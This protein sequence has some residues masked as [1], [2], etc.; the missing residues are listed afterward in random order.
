M[1]DAYE[2]SK[3][4][5]PQSLEADTPYCDKKFTFIQDINNGIYSGAGITLVQFDLSSIYNSSM[6]VDP[7]QMYLTIP[8]TYVACYANATLTG[9]LAQVA[10]NLR[11]SWATCGLKSGFFQIVHGGDL[12]VDGKTIEQFQPYQNAL[13]NF[14]MMSQMSQDD[15]NAYGPSLGMGSVIDNSRSV[16]YNNLNSSVALGVA[17]V[18]GTLQGPIGGNGITNC[19]PFG[20]P[21]GANPDF[22]DQTVYGPQCTSVYNTGLFSRISRIAD[23]T[24]CSQGTPVTVAGAVAGLYASPI[25]PGVLTSNPAIM[26]ATQLQ[27]EFRATYSTDGTY[28][29]WN[30]VAVIRLC[31]VFDSMGK[32]PLTKKFNGLLRLYIN[33][34]ACGAQMLSTGTSS[35]TM[36]TASASTFVNTCPLLMNNLTL[37]NASGAS[38]LVAGL[39]IARPQQTSIYG[40]NLANAT[41]SLGANP[42]TA[43][44]LYFPQVGLKAV[45]MDRYISENRSK[46]V[47]WRAN[48]FNQFSNITTGSSFSGLVQSGVS[49]IEG[50][51]IMPFLSA[52]TNGVLAGGGATQQI[53]GVTPFAQWASPFD[54]APA[55]SA[56][57]SLLNIQIAIGG[58]NILA[59]PYAYTFENFLNQVSLFDKI[60]R[61]DHGI[62]CG[63]ISQA[64]WEQSRVYYFDCSRGQNADLMTPRNVN[65]SFTNNSQQT[66]DCLIYTLYQDSCVIDCETGQISGR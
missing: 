32:F 49:N 59:S 2:F 18:V 22:G 33:T 20:A 39:F 7:A 58:Q 16:R 29:M 21:T 60:N 11:G 38:G 23:V 62:S 5:S 53:T 31:D 37:P 19:A 35:P 14:K 34:G 54:T 48:L 36:F 45:Q 1:S 61:S 9:P 64:F 26:S 10:G 63:L 25:Y 13:I 43:C 50:I 6:L 55:T 27:S 66:I 51:V 42:L 12:Q 41:Q 40:I 44:R 4:L 46:K 65:I 28:M 47:V 24:P 17:G 3:S 8:I 52:S 57:I 30:D 15:L 56:P